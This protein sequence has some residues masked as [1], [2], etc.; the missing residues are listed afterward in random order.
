MACVFPFGRLDVCFFVVRGGAFSLAFKPLE[1]DKD[2]M[3]RLKYV[4]F[5]GW[6]RWRIWLLFVPRPTRM[7]PPNK[8]ALNKDTSRGTGMIPPQIY[9][10]EI[11]ISGGIFAFKPLQEELT[12]IVTTWVFLGFGEHLSS[13]LPPKNNNSRDS[14]C[15]ESNSQKETHLRNPVCF[16]TGMSMVL[17]N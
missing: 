2:L 8:R 4:F 11:A 12:S 1:T 3:G 14:S 7:S 16:I 5:F 15:E 13:T 9:T 6:D 10:S 17:S